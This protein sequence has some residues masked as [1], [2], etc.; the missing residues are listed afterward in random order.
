MLNLNKPA[1]IKYLNKNPES[2]NIND[3]M[4]RIQHKKKTNCHT[5][6]QEYQNLDEER[7][8]TDTNFDRNQMLELCDKALKQ[9]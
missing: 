8:L 5:K 4:P 3:K 7:Q 2:L 9:P 6:N 1:K